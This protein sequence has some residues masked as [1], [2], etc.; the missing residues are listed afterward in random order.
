MKEI[1]QVD[2]EEDQHEEERGGRLV[3]DRAA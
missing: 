3:V 1:L 2:H